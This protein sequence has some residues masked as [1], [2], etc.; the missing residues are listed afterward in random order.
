MSMRLAI[1][2]TKAGAYLGHIDDK[3]E[4]GFNARQIFNVSMIVQNER[5]SEEIPFGVLFLGA[6]KPDYWSDANPV[7][8]FTNESPLL[9]I[10][11]IQIVC[12]SWQVELA[13]AKL[14]DKK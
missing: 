6:T 1:V 4:L 10:D 9:V 8:R 12:V 3:L 2:H 7:L 13:I 5:Q 11:V 14:K